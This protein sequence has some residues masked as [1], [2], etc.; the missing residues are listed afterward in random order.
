MPADTDPTWRRLEDQLGWYDRRSQAAQRAF[1]R[2]KVA[3][4]VLAAGVPVA[5]ASAAPGVLTAVLG[6]L[7]VVLEGIQ[8]LY[9]WQTNWVLYRATAEALKH[10][11]YLYEAQAGPYTGPD[12]HR[13]LAERIEGLVSQEHAR[14]TEGRQ[15]A[16]GGWDAAA[17]DRAR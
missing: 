15:H 12:R 7:V 1:K 14:W 16:T 9:Q 6:G 4:L 10:E 17:G 11:R 3:Q 5:V 2:V 8:Q 13:V